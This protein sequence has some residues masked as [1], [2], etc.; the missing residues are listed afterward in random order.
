[1]AAGQRVFPRGGSGPLPIPGPPLPPPPPPPLGKRATGPEARPSGCLGS[2]AARLREG[3]RGWGGDNGREAAGGGPWLWGKGSSC[4]A[5][6]ARA[7]LRPGPRPQRAGW[8]GARYSAIHLPKRQAPGLGR[9]EPDGPQAPVSWAPGLREP[10]C[11][12]GRRAPPLTRRELLITSRSLG[13]SARAGQRVKGRG[14]S[15]ESKQQRNQSRAEH[16]VTVKAPARRAAGPCAAAWGAGPLQ[17]GRH[18][19]PGGAVGARPGWTRRGHVGQTQG[20]KAGR[21]WGDGVHLPG[22]PPRAPPGGR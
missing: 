4:L 14:Q 17:A 10:T 22:C 3:R 18:S 5:V 1:M 15:S 2:P 8:E 20:R 11:R 19:G 9:G 12:Q 21:E 7:G 6:A 13:C 16:E